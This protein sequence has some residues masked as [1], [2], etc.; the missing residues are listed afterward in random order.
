LG[1]EFSLEKF[2]S[3]S[4]L[5][6]YGT[7]SFQGNKTGN[8]LADFLLGVPQTMNQDAPINKNENTWYMAFFFQDDFRI[9]PRLTLNLGLRYDLQTPDT[10][11][12][13]RKLTFVPGAQSKVVPNSLPGLLYPGDPGVSRGLVPFDTNNIG[14]RIGLAWDPFGDG[15]TSVRAAFGIFYGAVS[16]QEVDG[17]TNGQPFSIRQQFNTV[18]SL[19]DP[20]GSVP[21]GSP[22]PF[23]YNPASPKFSF[24]AGVAGMALDFVWPYT[25]QTNFSVQRQLSKDFSVTGAYVG[26]FGRR[27]P[28]AQEVNY[29]VFGA[30][31]TTANVNARRPYASSNLGAV[32]IV[33]SIMNTA[34]NGLQFTMDKRMSHN[35]SLKGFYTYGKSLEGARLQNDTSAGGAED[36]NN[37][38]LEHG[39]TDNDR[40]HNFVLSGFWLADYVHS[41]NRALRAIANG[42]TV[43]AIASARSG[44]PLTITAGT[45]INLDGTNNDRANLV[46]NPFLDPNRPR[47]AAAAMWF[48]TAAFVRPATGQDGNSGRNILDGPGLKNVDLGLFREFRIRESVKLQF[49]AETTNAFNIVNLSNPNT[50]FSSSLFGTI[51][52]ARPMRQSQLG[53]RLTF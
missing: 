32:A 33:K 53:L 24:P 48:N 17:S 52:T 26:A 7:F 44:E 4:T 50:T 39:R 36:M 11:P 31:A 41:G 2:V 51:R 8:A 1:A 10:D 42:W 13:D 9:H 20:Y 16:G 35:I 21:G 43:S 12:H 27:L 29:P 23:I 46:G 5:N 18:K 22:F 34:Y 14:P 28:F 40:R 19:T 49:R 47:S 25:Y 3:E 30:G 15:K 37:L 6:N 45:D 38:A